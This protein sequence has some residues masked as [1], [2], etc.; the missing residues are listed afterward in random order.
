L[1]LWLLLIGPLETTQNSSWVCQTGETENKRPYFQI[2]IHVHLR[3]GMTHIVGFHFI[4]WH[5]HVANGASTGDWGS[6][7][8]EFYKLI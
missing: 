3:D 4:W 8:I 5:I 6:K 1:F 7:F 2:K